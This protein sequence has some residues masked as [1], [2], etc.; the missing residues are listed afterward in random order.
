MATVELE[1][2]FEFLYMSYLKR[3]FVELK[4]S[5]LMIVFL[6]T[7][8]LIFMGLQNG[9]I[10][11]GL[12]V[13]YHFIEVSQW[14]RFQLKQIRFETEYI[15]IEYYHYNKRHLV[16]CK[17]ES[18]TI[19]KEYLRYKASAVR[20]YLIFV[21]NK[22]VLFK[23][24]NVLDINKTVAQKIINYYFARKSEKIATL[25]NEKSRS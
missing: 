13:G 20:F 4:S 9:G 17:Y 22:K 11:I 21:C 12:V 25:N 10:L 2:G 19:A 1:N 16:E 7:I 24:H 18:L 15:F 23:Q 5:L 3:I 14:T 8:A 6:A